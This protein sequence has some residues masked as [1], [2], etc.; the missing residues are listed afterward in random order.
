MELGRK[1]YHDLA[2][3]R[4]AILIGHNKKDSYVYGGNK[5]H[6]T[7]HHNWFGP[8]LAGRPY[9]VA[10]CMPII[11]TLTIA[12]H[13]MVSEPLPMV[14]AMKSSSTTLCR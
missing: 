3:E 5:L 6:V 8:N 10:G 12:H 1:N 11:I 14:A 4:L 9:C 2:N 13:L 7:L